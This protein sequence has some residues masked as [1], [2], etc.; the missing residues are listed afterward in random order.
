MIFQKMRSNSQSYYMLLK[1]II[2]SNYTNKHEA[3]TS[4]KKKK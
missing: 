1:Q 4:N 2:L 3:S